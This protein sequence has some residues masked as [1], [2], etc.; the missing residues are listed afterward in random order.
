MGRKRISAVF[1]NQSLKLSRFPVSRPYC[2][3]RSDLAFVLTSVLSPTAPFPSIFSVITGLGKRLAFAAVVDGAPY[4]G[5][6]KT[7]SH[8]G[9]ISYF[10]LVIAHRGSGQLIGHLALQQRRS[11][12]TEGVPVFN[13]RHIDRYQAVSGQQL[14]SISGSLARN[15]ICFSPERVAAYHQVSVMSG[16]ER[17]LL[18]LDVSTRCKK[19]ITTMHTD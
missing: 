7:R 8:R 2:R 14:R 5:G 19:I 4:Q 16:V 11:S 12:V 9:S 15:G 17:L 18:N 13:F 10:R 6:L 1:L 3:S